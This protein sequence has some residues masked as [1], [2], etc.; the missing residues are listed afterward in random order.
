MV[1]LKQET[2]VEP[3]GERLRAMRLSLG[4]SQRVMAEELGG[5]VQSLWA[6]IEGGHTPGPPVIAAIELLC[7]HYQPDRDPITARDFHPEV[8]IDPD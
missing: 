4:K 8:A 2:V 3:P 7:L 5:Y 6:M 1:K